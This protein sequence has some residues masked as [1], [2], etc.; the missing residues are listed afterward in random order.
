MKLKKIICILL[1][2]LLLLLTG[3]AQEPAEDVTWYIKEQV[4][5][6]FGTQTT[7][8]VY[9]YNQDWSTG[10]ITTYVDGELESTVTYERTETGYITRGTQ[11]GVEDVMELVITRDE[12]GNAIRTEQYLNGQLSS[13][14]EATFDGQGNMLTYDTHVVGPDLY[15]HQETE[16]DAK[17]NKTKVTVDN[18]YGL[19]VTEYVYDSQNRLIKESSPESNAWT[20]YAYEDSGKL[21]TALIYGENGELTNK[22]I[23]TY[24]DYGNLL[25][26]ETYD[27]DGNIVLTTACSYVSTDGRISSGIEG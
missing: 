1:T 3:C 18:G 17:G 22:R 4:R 21:E 23:S 14:A 10:S 5:T 16:Y 25:L 19:T 9:E 2:A 8:S 13:T 12:A 26:Q 7:H 27:A 11:D 6:F 24:D 15:L 20:E